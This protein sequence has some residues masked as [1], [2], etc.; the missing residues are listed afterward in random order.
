MTAPTFAFLAGLFNIAL[1]VFHMAFSRLF[2]WPR[3]LAGL[4]PLN[5]GLMHVLNLALT[6]MFLVVGV[7]L[8]AEPRESA[9][10]ALGR[11]LLGGMTLF[12][13]ARLLVQKPFFGLR[14]P[15]AIGLAVVFA[16]GIALHGGALLLPS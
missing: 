15:M 1:A 9:G 5:R 4:D 2:R 12:W 16:I 8:A 14:H 11:W 6:G 3:K 7:A 13:L 10:T